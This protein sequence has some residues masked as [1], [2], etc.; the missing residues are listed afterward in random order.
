MYLEIKKQSNRYEDVSAFLRV[1]WL[2]IGLSVVAIAGCATGHEYGDTGTTVIS[3]AERLFSDHYHLVVSRRVG[4]VTNHSAI[5][6]MQHLADRLHADPSIELV[7]LFGPEHG[8]RGTADAG[9]P[10]DHGVDERTGVPVYSLYGATRAPTEEMLEGV[11]VLVFDMQDIG[12]RFYTYITTMALSMAS[13]AEHGVEFVVLDR[14]NPIN[15][16]KVEG[17]IPEDDLTFTSIS[18]RPIPTRHGMTIGELALMFNEEWGGIGCDLTVVEVENWHRAMYFDQTGLHWEHPS[19]NM[20]TMNGAILY[21]GLGAGEMTSLSTG[22]G[23]DRPFE[24]YGAP[25]MDGQA[26]AENLANR[27][28][29]G[30]RFVPITFVPTAPYHRFRDEECG[31]VFA[32]VYDRD[33]LDSVTAGLHMMQA[34]YETHPEDYVQMT[35]FPISLGSA[36]VWD[37]L[38]GGEM[39][40]EEIVETFQPE[41]DEF[42]EM[43][44]QYLL[45]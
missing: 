5:V 12:T 27:N 2:C 30:V 3:G 26:V 16:V 15:G 42:L 39:T 37:M 11:D 1:A 6:G 19:P 22:R 28:T 33:A 44:E 4:L 31:G 36:E 10:V 38:T 41:L 43:R 35:R 7:A 9:E 45:Y 18:V 34:M 40:P 14:P 32:I 23:L 24:K 21:P 17:A 25:Y 8:I 20:K 29:P 13:A